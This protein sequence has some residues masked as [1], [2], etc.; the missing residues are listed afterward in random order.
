MY[1][2]TRDYIKHGNARSGQKLLRVGFIV[3]HDTGNPGSTAYNNR[4]YF[5]NQQPSASAQ[6]FIDDKYILEIIPI[7]EK[8][9]HVQYQKTKDNELYGD[10][11]NDIAI[12]VELCYGKSI[13]F[14]EA[15]KRYVWY[16]AYL[17]KSFSLDPRKHIVAHATLDPGRKTD[18]HNA[19]NQNGI[20]W[21]IFINDVV[22]AMNPNGW[23]KENSHWYYFE[24]GLPKTGWLNDNNKWYFLDQ[25]GV[26]ITGWVKVL[27]KWYY[28]DSSGAMKTGWINDRGTWYYLAA[29]GDMQTGWIQDNGK[30]YF[31]KADGSMAA[32][33]EVPVKVGSDGALILGKG[34]N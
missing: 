21:D 6:T 29:N 5:N 8:A 19:L 3:A 32:N 27:E 26:M 22:K 15:Y 25:N 11:A 1:E 31:L 12:G 9:W 18:P 20:T 17:C 14:L 10:D 16:M 28:L 23:S 24:N 30:W 7:Y 34:T 13:N 33:T 4:N 2:I